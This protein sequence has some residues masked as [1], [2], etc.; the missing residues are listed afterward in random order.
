MYGFKILEFLNARYFFL[1]ADK[2]GEFLLPDI[3]Y[4]LQK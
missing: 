1:T 4:I 3:R 2:S